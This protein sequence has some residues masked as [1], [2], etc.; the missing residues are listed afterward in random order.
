MGFRGHGVW[1]HGHGVTSHDHGIT[2]RGHGAS[3]RGHGASFRGHGA[4]FHGHGASFR[5][6]VFGLISRGSP[7]DVRGI[8]GGG[9]F[10]GPD[11][12]GDRWLEKVAEDPTLIEGPIASAAKYEL[13][14][15]I[16]DSRSPTFLLPEAA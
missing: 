5:F 14:R 10:S 6:G 4:S 2:R 8:A 13:S 16:V 12:A 1:C 7:T 9:G 3:F 15:A 11:L